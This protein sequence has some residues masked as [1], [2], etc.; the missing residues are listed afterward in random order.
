MIVEN[1][2]LDS[3][4]AV[5]TDLSSLARAIT[6]TGIHGPAVIFVG[7]DWTKRGCRGPTRSRCTG[8]TTREPQPAKPA[9]PQRRSQ[10]R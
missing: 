7:L 5:A 8:R 4:R 3:E 2:T 6:D 10:G 9:P 1:G